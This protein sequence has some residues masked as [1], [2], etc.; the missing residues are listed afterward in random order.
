MF[1]KKDSGSQ[2][3]LSEIMFSE[4]FRR[5]S[6]SLLLYHFNV[7]SL[8]FLWLQPSG[9]R[10]CQSSDSYYRIALQHNF[11]YHERH[12]DNGFGINVSYDNIN[13]Y[14]KITG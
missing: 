12:V 11:Y 3:Y 1:L 6:Y 9:F 2:T 10:L 4:N 7:S 5:R 8:P 13:A 14:V